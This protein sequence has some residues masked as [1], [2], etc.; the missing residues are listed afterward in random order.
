MAHLRFSALGLILAVVL[1]FQST[2]AQQTSPPNND[3]AAQAALREKAFG[4]LESLSDQVANLQSAENRARIGSNI[5][6]SIWTHDDKRARALFALAEQDISVALQANSDRAGELAV[7]LKLREDI[8][9]RIS[10]HDA[11]LAFAFLQ[12][13]KP[14]SNAELPSGFKQLE[15][16]LELYLGKRI[17]AEN[18]EVALKLARQSL[19]QGFSRDLLI[20]L[21]RLERKDKQQAAVL[22]KDIVA[23]VRDT[24][25]S[26]R[27]QDL[28][29]TVDLIRFV[30][31]PD[32]SSYRELINVLVA[33]ANTYGCGPRQ[34]FPE[35]DGRLM[36]CRQIGGLLSQMQNGS[37]RQALADGAFARAL[38]AQGFYELDDLADGPG[39]IDE[40]LALMTKYPELEGHIRL[41]AMW[42]AE[43][44][45]DF[46]R[47][48]KIGGA[49]SG[50]DAQVRRA[51]DVRLKNYA[52][53]A[54]M[55][56]QRLAE[57]QKRISQS[58]PLEQ[59]GMW[60]GLASQ[61]APQ[62]SKLAL[63]L[64]NQ[65]SG[66]IDALPPG[67]VQLG[68]QLAMATVYCSARSD[69]GFAIMESVLPKLNE[70]VAAAVKLDGFDTRYIRDGEWN[71][72]AEGSTGR[73]L[74]GLTQFAGS[75]A[76]Y[77]FDR[78]INLAAQFERPEIR[79]MA[80]L[81]LAQGVL[82]GPPKRLPFVRP[83]I[84]D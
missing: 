50:N 31:P 20:L 78:A 51:I 63:R 52:A 57:L 64:L 42:K 79:M 4:V 48:T 56:E 46:E 75:F 40:I 81:K 25:L 26:Q 77:D 3:E 41:R 5:A 69:R 1:C 72:S 8:V 6:D 49:Y 66:M 59:I 68:A 55:S 43:I 7:F 19:A 29:F 18:P 53:S 39:T 84:I 17:A 30:E 83:A 33:K 67:E 14:P 23:K 38:P 60:L 62:N 70:L 65:V 27:W 32:D 73:L 15:Q 44:A 9:G 13:T 82:A 37:Q 58:P 76:W 36:Y 34:E 80:Q 35:G 71:M 10:K 12:R 16:S 47:A 22:Y 45:G 28:N 54:E 11:E 2:H 61:M 21:I 74:N 24:D